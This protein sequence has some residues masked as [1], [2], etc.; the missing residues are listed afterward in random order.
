[1]EQAARK[2]DKISDDT[3]ST[4]LSQIN[5]FEMVVVILKLKD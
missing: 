3:H 1:M 4:T 2:G 5:K